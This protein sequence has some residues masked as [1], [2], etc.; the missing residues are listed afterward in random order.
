MAVK[1][2]WVVF[3]RGAI[4]ILLVGS[5][6]GSVVLPV[7]IAIGKIGA[8]GFVTLLTDRFVVRRLTPALAAQAAS[9]VALLV[10]GKHS[11]D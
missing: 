1:S 2:I 4:I 8:D 5:V 10:V 3:G 7:L 9:P 6:R 11:A